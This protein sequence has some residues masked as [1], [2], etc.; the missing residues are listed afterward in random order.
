MDKTKFFTHRA[1]VVSFTLICCLLW[2][3]AFPCIKIGCGMFD[4]DSASTSSQILFA[5]LRFG[6]LFFCQNMDGRCV[7]QEERDTGNGAGLF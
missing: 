4:I 6:G 7:I 3:S 5:G 2:G 1:V